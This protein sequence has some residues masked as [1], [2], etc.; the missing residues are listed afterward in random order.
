[1]SLLDEIRKLITGERTQGEMSEAYLG[2]PE[3]MGTS[4]ATIDKLI[5]PRSV[6]NLPAHMNVALNQSPKSANYIAPELANDNGVLSLLNG[7]GL[8]PQ[9]SPTDNSYFDAIPYSISGQRPNYDGMSGDLSSYVDATRKNYENYQ[10][11]QQFMKEALRDAKVTDEYLNTLNET[12]SGNNWGSTESGQGQPFN[13]LKGNPDVVNPANDFTLYADGLNARVDSGYTKDVEKDSMEQTI[14]DRA[15][16]KAEEKKLTE[17]SSNF[18]SYGQNMPVSDTKPTL[19]QAD[20]DKMTVNYTNTGEKYTK[21][22]TDV[23]FLDKVGDFVGNKERMLKLA[24]AFNS[25]RLEP[26]QGLATA[27]NDRLKT[28]SKQGKANSTAE[29]LRNKGRPDLADLVLKNPELTT[30]ALQEVRQ[31]NKFKIMKGADL[32]KEYGITGLPSKQNF[33]YNTLTGEISGIGQGNTIIQTV[34]PDTGYIFEYNP[35]GSIA[36]QVPI[37]KE[38]TKDEIK[39]LNEKASA[40]SISGTV[41][42]NAGNNIADKLFGGKNFMPVTGMLGGVTAEFIGES[43]A[44]VVKRNIEVLGANASIE[45]LQNMRNQSKTG[46]ALGNVTERELAMLKA[47]KGALD[48][49]YNTKEFTKAYLEYMNIMFKVVYGDTSEL[50]QK[51]GVTAGQKAYDE[52]LSGIKSKYELD[53]NMQKTGD[54]KTE[55]SQ[56]QIVD[57][58][59]L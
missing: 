6:R 45:T 49:T 57:F 15:K 26:D 47:S 27:L 8:N 58:N 1:M 31:S 59:D 52:W 13:P 56:S 22:N 12:G 35:D 30:Q 5:S 23:S 54:V 41:I 53:D 16:E 25:M 19:S 3:Y 10:T 37:E 42:S 17:G 7:R 2:N 50:G 24:L 48:Q 33:K 55:D 38:L 34:K 44:R 21:D 4:R 43:D 39:M 9:S 36:R 14:L 51:Y 32:E 40:K 29:Y 20:V 28:L 46:G 11:D 18:V